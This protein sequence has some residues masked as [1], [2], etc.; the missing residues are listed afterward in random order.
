MNRLT[1]IGNLTNDVELRTTQDGI[2]VCS[3]SVAVNRRNKKEGQPDADFFRV[4]A[5]RGLGESCAKYLTK[6]KKVAVIGSV[7]LHTYQTQ[8]GKHGASME[9]LASDVEFLSSRSESADAQSGMTKVEPDDL[10][11]QFETPY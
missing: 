4:T 7:S 2:S 8:N 11:E 5:W 10:P 3:F 6:G 1:I 9:V